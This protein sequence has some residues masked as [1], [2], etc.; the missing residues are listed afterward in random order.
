[1]AVASAEISMKVMPSSQKSEF[2]PGEYTLLLNGV[3]M[4]QPLSGATPKNRLEIR[5]SPPNR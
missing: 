1:M 4:N 2:A 5:I 3:Y